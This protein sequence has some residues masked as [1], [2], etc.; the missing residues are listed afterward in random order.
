MENRSTP[1][2]WRYAVPILLIIYLVLALMHMQSVPTGQT[3]YQNAPDEAAH[4][5]YVRTLA[6][7]HLPKRAESQNNPVGYEWHQPPLYYVFA[8]PLSGMNDRAVRSISIFFGLCAIILVAFAAKLLFPQEPLIWALSAALPALLPTHIAITSAV[9]NDVLLEVCFSGCLLLLISSLYN[10]FTSKRAIWLG[11]WIGSA[12]LTKSN[13]LLLVPISIFGCLLFIKNGESGKSVWRSYGISLL[14]A[15]LISVWWYLHNFKLYGELLPLK[16]F[17][18]AFAGTIQAKDV[19][20]GKIPGLGVSNW[21]EY[22]SLV[23]KWTFQSFWAVFGTARSAAIGAPRFMPDQYY[24]LMGLLTIC[25]FTGLLR[26][27][28]RKDKDYTAL[29]VSCIQLFWA[30][31]IIVGFSFAGFILKYFQTQGRYLY[32]AMLPLSLLFAVGWRSLIPAKYLS[33][34]SAGL[35][36]LLAVLALLF[37]RYTLPA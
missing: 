35:I 17:E 13:G 22:I 24:Q 32:P 10:G 9:N 3:G 26:A 25:L 20:A 37:I 28:F 21:T 27:H 30:S 8:L 4:L 6:G 19:A 11:F 12:L 1:R 23:T 2:T 15:A 29:Q 18:Q 34:A 5:T 16:A 33:A 36:S 7:G 31:F 14:A